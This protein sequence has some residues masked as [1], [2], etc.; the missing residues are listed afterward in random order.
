MTEIL[1]W[2]PSGNFKIICPQTVA[3][4]LALVKRW[5]SCP[6]QYALVGWTSSCKLKGCSFYSQWQ[7]IDIVLPHLYFSP[8]LSLY[9]SIKKVG[10]CNI[11]FL[12][13][14]RIK[15]SKIWNQILSLK[16]SMQFIH[17]FHTSSTQWNFCSN[18][19]YRPKIM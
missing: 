19:H 12:H 13:W 4:I 8:F 17:Y 15:I 6:G 2:W 14:R 11:L 7:P 10:F 5:L 16:K 18:L 1:R 3:D 9:K